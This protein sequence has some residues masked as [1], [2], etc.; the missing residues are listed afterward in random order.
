MEKQQQEDAIARQIKEIIKQ[1]RM[2]VC[3]KL[4][5][6]PALKKHFEKRKQRCLCLPASA[7]QRRGGQRARVITAP[8]HGLSYTEMEF[9]MWMK[10]Y[11]CLFSEENDH[12]K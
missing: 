7:R 4:M 12:V 9:A 11:S 6:D 3:S 2:S 10:I 1:L 8:A 5:N